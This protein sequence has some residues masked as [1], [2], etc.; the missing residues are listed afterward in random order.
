MQS[1]HSFVRKSFDD[2]KNST[3]TITEGVVVNMYEKLNTIEHMKNSLFIDNTNDENGKP[4]HYYNITDRIRANQKSAEDIDTKDATIDTDTAKYY[5]QSFLLSK[6]NQLWMKKARIGTFLNDFVETRGD[7]GGVL[8]RK[9]ETADDL[10]LEV[11]DWHSVACDPTDIQNGSKVILR[12]M[13]PKELI[14][15]SKSKG[16]VY[17]DDMVHEAIENGLSTSRN[18]LGETDTTPTGYIPVYEIE[19]VLPA[20][21]FD[22]EADEYDYR[23]YYCITAN[24]ERTEVTEEKMEV[25]SGSCLFF[26]EL[27]KSNFKYKEY[28]ARAGARSTLGIGTIEKS[29]EGQKNTNFVINEQR[30]ALE[31]AGKVTLQ[32]ADRGFSGKNVTKVDHGTIFKVGS[33]LSQVNMTPSAM[34]FYQEL[35]E[36]W[37]RQVDGANS[38]H[39]INTGEKTPSNMSYRL[40]ATLNQEANSPF[41]QKREEAALFLEDIWREWVIPFLI[42]QI[43]KDKKISQKFTSEELIAIDNSTAAWYADQKA[44]YDYLNGKF[45]DL[46]PEE[47]LLA[48]NEARAELENEYKTKLKATKD[49]RTITF[50]DDYFPEGVEYEFNIPITNE[51]KQKDVYFEAMSNIL[52]TYLANPQVRK[53]PVAR[54]IFNSI[55]EVSG[56][57]PV[58]FDALEASTYS[59]QELPTNQPSAPQAQTEEAIAQPQ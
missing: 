29:M 18:E 33:P 2:Y 52:Q 46:A 14:D 28:N 9:R 56:A 23:L 10:H 45:D 51:Q 1:I 24:S 34:G 40:G 59:A 4:K 58:Q 37:G 8:V 54:S 50:P 57:K 30:K 42:K 21:M 41:S 3:L 44:I 47:R 35:F 5:Y 17:D 20:R 55:M 39:A 13:T 6:Y 7:Y 16:G 53:D 32:T 38:T 19:A 15:M 26:E 48:L 25:D 43:K 49:K 27:E 22:Q 11:V 12:Y 36:N 31:L